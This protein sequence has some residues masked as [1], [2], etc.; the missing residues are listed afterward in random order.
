MEAGSRFGQVLYVHKFGLNLVS[1]SLSPTCNHILIGLAK[2]RVIAQ[3]HEKQ[4]SLLKY[5]RLL[6]FFPTC[7][8]I[9]QI[10]IPPR[11]RK[12]DLRLSK[13]G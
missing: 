1:V 7:K 2:G 12:N 10:V 4:V 5:T 9:Y 3:P 13:A 6:E 11:N 8:L